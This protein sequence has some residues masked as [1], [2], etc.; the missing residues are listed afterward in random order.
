LARAIE[1]APVYCTAGAKVF[2]VG[3][4]NSGALTLYKNKARF[5]QRT[6]RTLTGL[7][8][9]LSEITIA[10][11]E[12]IAFDS[13]EYVP[14][15]CCRAAQEPSPRLAYCDQTYDDAERKVFFQEALFRLSA[16]LSER[17]GFLPALVSAPPF[18]LS[19]LSRGLSLRKHR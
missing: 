2:V 16:E 7:E 17:F 12:G 18:N 14:G 19:N 8:G 11:K 6:P 13:D 9:L 5:E 4:S 10:G 3:L 1:S 15:L